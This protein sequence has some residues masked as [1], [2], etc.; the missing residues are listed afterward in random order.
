[1]TKHSKQFAHKVLTMSKKNYSKIHKNKL[2]HT[3]NC[4]GR[5]PNSIRTL[6]TYTHTTWHGFCYLLFYYNMKWMKTHTVV[7]L[8]VRHLWW[9]FFVLHYNWLKHDV[10]LVSFEISYFFEENETTHGGSTSWWSTN[11]NNFFT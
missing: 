10:I 4:Q 7:S 11:S 3:F 9:N 6:Q 8:S 2:K 5:W 1:M